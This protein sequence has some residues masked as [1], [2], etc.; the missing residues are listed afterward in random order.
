[1]EKLKTSAIVMMAIVVAAATIWLASQVAGSVMPVWMALL[2]PALL[3]GALAVHFVG[4]K[5]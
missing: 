2:G 5:R 3:I 4:R 1:M